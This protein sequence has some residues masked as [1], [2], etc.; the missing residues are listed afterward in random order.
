[1]AALRNSL[2][3]RFIHSDLQGLQDVCMLELGHAFPFLERDEQVRGFGHTVELW[4]NHWS[5]WRSQSDYKKGLSVLCIGGLSGSGKT[6][7]VH[8]AV[9]QLP[10]LFGTKPV[11]Q[12]LL[13]TC[14]ERQLILD[15][16]ISMMQPTSLGVATKLLESYV[17]GFGGTTF[18]KASIGTFLRQAGTGQEMDRL[19]EALTVGE[20]NSNQDLLVF[21]RLDE[22]NEDIT[23]EHTSTIVRIIL[24]THTS[25]TRCCLIPILSGTDIQKMQGASTSS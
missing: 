13:Q 25:L 4:Y 20:A 16:D 19:V 12:K 2:P 24:S 11:F 17:N 8:E 10:G 9:K 22:V 3:N 21:V 5:K 15:V 14:A 6:R 23:V 7:F 1:M 18:S